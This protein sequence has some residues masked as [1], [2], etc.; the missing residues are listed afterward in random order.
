MAAGVAVP[1][2][3]ASRAS[4]SAGCA[5]TA[6]N[7]VTRVDPDPNI[8]KGVKGTL[9]ARC[10]QRHNPATLSVTL[11]FLVPS[12]RWVRQGINEVAGLSMRANHKYT[13]DTGFGLGCVTGEYQT[14]AILIFRSHGKRVK[15]SAN[16]P[17]TAITC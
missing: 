8:G 12:H 4:K 14:R 17:N 6:L 10:G 13:I 7:P 3:Q 11:W 2:A 1:I 15:L 16:S 9:T 5:L